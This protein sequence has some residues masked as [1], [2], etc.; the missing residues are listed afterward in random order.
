MTLSTTSS[1][2]IYNGD[3]LIYAQAATADLARRLPIDPG[4]AML[5]GRA[6]RDDELRDLF[7]DGHSYVIMHEEQ[8]LAI[9]GAVPQEPGNALVYAFIAASA[10]NRLVAVTRVLRRLIEAA[11]F[12]RLEIVVRSNDHRRIRWLRLLGF[13]HEGTARAW[14]SDGED[15]ERFARVRRTVVPAAVLHQTEASHLSH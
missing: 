1:Q 8:V 3:D 15:G 10:A 12:R 13:V 14:A 6:P 5:A 4:S 11:P 2:V 7:A 9:A